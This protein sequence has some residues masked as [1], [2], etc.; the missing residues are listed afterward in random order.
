M[1][2]LTNR[3]E[4][5]LYERTSQIIEAARAHV[6]RTVNTAMVLAYWL[7]GREIV[8]VD[9][10]GKERAEYGE[11]VVQRLADRLSARFGRGFTKS[12]VKRM[13]QFYLSFPDG[14]CLPEDLGGPRKGA[15]AEAP[16]RPHPHR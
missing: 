9:Q 3:G 13:R 4:E 15:P 1:S 6:S 7:V 10:A 8:E 14:S 16:L 2:D 11:G 12:N 5:G